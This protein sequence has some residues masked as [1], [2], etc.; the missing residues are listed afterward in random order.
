M[1]RHPRHITLKR[2]WPQ[3]YFSGLSRMLKFTRERE[4]MKRRK[5]TTFKL[6]KS[7]SFAKPRKSR[8]T[9]QFHKV[10]P[11]LKFNKSLISKRTGIPLKALDTV[12]DRGRRAWQT[13]GSRPGMT[14]NQWGVAR[15]Y[16]YILVTKKKAPRAWYANRFDP[17]QDL[18]S[19]GL[20]RRRS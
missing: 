4:L 1:K 5:S 18:R 3:R 11:G 17:D 12:Y 14:A 15:T 8:W 7:N 6:R 9:L 2:T 10:Y 19:H 20:S 13:G 16:K